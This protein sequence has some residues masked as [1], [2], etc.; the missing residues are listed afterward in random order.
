MLHLATYWLIL[1]SS[2]VQVLNLSSYSCHPWIKWFYCTGH[3]SLRR[4]TSACLPSVSA[5]PQYS[6]PSSIPSIVTKQE[7]HTNPKE[8]EVKG[9]LGNFSIFRLARRICHVWAEYVLSRKNPVRLAGNKSYDK[10][11]LLSGPHN[12]SWL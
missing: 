6:K 5:H 1:C 11:R 9:D 10:S 7:N 2:T 8:S 4:C 3:G 12:N